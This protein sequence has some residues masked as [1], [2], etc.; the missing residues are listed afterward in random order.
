MANRN[1]GVVQ[2]QEQIQPEQMQSEEY[3]A[4]D[5]QQIPT[6]EQSQSQSQQPETVQNP[7]IPVQE[8]PLPQGIHDDLAISDSEDEPE[9]QLSIYKEE[10]NE[11]DENEGEGL[12][13]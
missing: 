7:I 4:Q 11:D 13:F 3:I 8:E 9:L 6:F 10:K 5:L 1:I 12:W 2:Q